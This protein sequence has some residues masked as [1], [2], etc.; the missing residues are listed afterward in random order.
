M[1]DEGAKRISWKFHSFQ[2]LSLQ[3]ASNHRVFGAMG[4]ISSTPATG[5]YMGSWPNINNSPVTVVF[6]FCGF[7]DFPVELPVAGFLG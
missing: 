1:G 7:P 5:K 4:H 2:V 3:S 6:V